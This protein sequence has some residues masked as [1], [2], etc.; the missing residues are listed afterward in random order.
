MILWV[1]VRSPYSGGLAAI[2]STDP[3]KRPLTEITWPNSHRLDGFGF[4]EAA[5][6]EQRTPH[7]NPSRFRQ[8]AQSRADSIPP[9]ECH[10]IEIQRAHG[11]HAVLIGQDYLRRQSPNR[12]R[13]R[14][15]NNFV[16]AVD[17]FTS[18]EDENGP[19]LVGKPKGVPAD[20]AL[21]STDVV[22]ALGPALGVPSKR[23]VVRGKLVARR[24]YGPVNG[25][26]AAL[27]RR[28]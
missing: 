13:S 6:D 4:I 21:A 26:V 17:E 14:Y 12:S 27:W 22:P 24:W 19:A 18:R 23:L 5:R 11:W 28:N 1:R 8:T 15:N 10:V 16:Q 2:D 7:F 20:L 9:R 25:C 3:E